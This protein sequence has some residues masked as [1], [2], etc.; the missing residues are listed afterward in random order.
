M[1]PEEGVAIRS[2]HE[3]PRRILGN[4]CIIT[5]MPSVWEIIT[6]VYAY[7]R[8]LDGGYVNADRNVLLYDGYWPRLCENSSLKIRMCMRVLSFA[9]RT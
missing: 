8:I 5:P 7:A 9:V 4:I 1:P 6:V 3:P 2:T